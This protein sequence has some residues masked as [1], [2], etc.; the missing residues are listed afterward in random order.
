MHRI[1]FRLRV[2]PNRLD[3]YLE[4]HRTVWPD[5]LAD[6]RAAGYRNYSIFADG[7]ELFGYL[8]CDDW[9]AAQKALASS[10]ANRR[11]QAWMTEY[12]ET[13]VDPDLERPLHLLDRVFFME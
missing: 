5:L 6:M 9:D 2:K 13:P 4:I 12:L 3:E 8:E 7:N 11:W 10:D 1:A